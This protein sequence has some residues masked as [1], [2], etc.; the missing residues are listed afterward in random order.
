MA[1]IT[2]SFPKVGYDGH[3]VMPFAGGGMPRV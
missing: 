1:V 2:I 3:F